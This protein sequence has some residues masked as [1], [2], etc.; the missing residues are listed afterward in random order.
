MFLVLRE[1]IE[2]GP[3]N[4]NQ[5]IDLFR[6]GKLLLKDQIR[7]ENTDKYILIQ[8][9]IA[10]NNLKVKQNSESVSSIF[11]NLFQ[12]I[13]SFVKF[14]EYL[15]SGVQSNKELLLMIAIVITPIAGLF[16]VQFPI[17]VYC[18]Y[19]LY[20]A[21]IW[22]LILYKSIAT[23]QVTISKSVIVFIGTILISILVISIVHLTPI[24]PLIKEYNESE[25]LIFRFISM[26]FGVAIIEEFCKQVFIYGTINSN[27]FVTTTR[28]AI[29]YGMLAG[30]SFGIF[31]GVEYQI[32][33]NKEMEIDANYFFNILRLTSLPFFH[34]IWAG[35]GAYLVSLSFILIKF[36]FS[37]RI[38]A[39]LI[40]AFFHALYNTLGLTIIGIGVVIIS[41]L[42]LIVYLTKSNLIN[43]Q[44]NF[45]QNE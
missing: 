32:G 2:Y 45:N 7:H 15:T 23:K 8:E 44:I 33:I 5:I 26:F 34:A 6:C 18:I 36:R 35:I 31:E 4:A 27:K 9:F 38:M 1:K 42:L 12:L 20:F 16:L 39:V 17:I 21:A 19:G 28:T 13:P 11:S 3:F 29:F 24:G 43:N 22:S 40:P 37:F 10:I 14:W 30:I 41:F 25:N